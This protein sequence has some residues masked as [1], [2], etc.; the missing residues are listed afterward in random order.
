M[1]LDSL[2]ISS[3][4]DACLNLT[5]KETQILFR[6]NTRPGSRNVVAGNL[7]SCEQSAVR[8]LD[9][10]CDPGY[11]ANDRPERETVRY[12]ASTMENLPSATQSDK[13]WSTR[14]QWEN[15]S[16]AGR[17]PGNEYSPPRQS[18]PLLIEMAREIEHLKSEL[19]AF[20]SGQRPTNRIESWSPEPGGE[21]IRSGM[22]EK[23]RAD[24][25]SDYAS[26]P[27]IPVK[28]D[29]GNLWPVSSLSPLF[30]KHFEEQDISDC[31]N[32]TG[33]GTDDWRTWS[34]FE[35]DHQLLSV[36]DLP[37]VKELRA[38]VARLQDRLKSTSM[39]HPPEDAALN[40]ANPAS[41][42]T[43]TESKTV[44]HLRRVIQ[45]W[46]LLVLVFFHHW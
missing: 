5:G 9:A 36:N 32:N 41:E 34:G 18:S 25:F 44:L 23:D 26:S 24:V 11:V 27:M 31:M 45:V 19:A 40:T 35:Q 14:G 2:Q 21:L 7:R 1:S 4:I 28:T 20:Q 13:E 6:G 37:L 38:E 39:M 29:G 22:E 15:L 46:L 43:S 17:A 33:G 3:E 12:R 30:G 42:N 16:M 8:S 10:L